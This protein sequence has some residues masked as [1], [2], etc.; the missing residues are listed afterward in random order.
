MEKK[1]PL[2][3][4]SSESDTTGGST[5]AATAEPLVGKP[6]ARASRTRAAAA[7]PRE[8]A[9]RRAA[10][11]DVAPAH[12]PSAMEAYD[13]AEAASSAIEQKKVPL[14]DIIAHAKIG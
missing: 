10:A 2:P 9:P 14:S 13:I 5:P 7:S 11:G 12:T 8:A 6:A 1:T 4:S 3:T